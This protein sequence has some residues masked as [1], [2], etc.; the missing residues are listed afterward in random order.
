VNVFDPGTVLMQTLP[1]EVGIFDDKVGA[2]VTLPFKVK[3]SI[4]KVPAVPVIPVKVINTVNIPVW[5]ATALETVVVPIAAPDV[6]VVPDPTDIPL[7][8]MAQLVGP[9]P[10]LCLQK[11]NEVTEA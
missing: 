8:V 5:L 3:S 2:G 1:N 10:L 11:L 9:V 6:G 7:M 4:L